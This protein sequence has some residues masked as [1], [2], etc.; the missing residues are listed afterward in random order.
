M[1]HAMSVIAVAGLATIASAQEFSLSIGAPTAVAS[2][3]IFSIDIF[4]D[5][6]VG[7]HMLGGAFSLISNSGSQ[8][9]NMTWIPAAWSVFN[10]DGGY[11]GNGNYN[12]VIFGQIVIPGIPGF[13]LPAAG[14]E[15]GGLIGSFEVTLGLNA[16]C[17][18]FTI[19]AGAPFTLETIT[20]G[21]SGSFQSTSDNL[22]LNGAFIGPCPSPSSIALLGLGGL[23]AGRRRR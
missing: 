8:I 5:A 4:G 6:S 1:K 15:L 2:G 18:D 21:V 22:I 13:D 20:Q 14:S 19:V 7:T 23:V 16:P 3:T 10:T 11:A 17:L 12:Q 9:T